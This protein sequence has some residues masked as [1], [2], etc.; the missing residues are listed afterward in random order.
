MKHLIAELLT[1]INA[2]KKAMEHSSP[3]A[4]KTYLKDHPNADKSKHTVKSDSKSDSSKS[5][6]PSVSD[7]TKSLDS[8][9][10]KLEDQDLSDY[11]IKQFK[12]KVEYGE[13]H[14]VMFLNSSLGCHVN[15][16]RLAGEPHGRICGATWAE[17]EKDIM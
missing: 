17:M 15:H 7:A 1:E 11:D 14:N 16:P 4:L 6:T 9:K 12:Q 13:G 2:Y 8:A 3:E 10:K 5:N